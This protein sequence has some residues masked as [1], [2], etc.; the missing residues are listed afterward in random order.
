M[1]KLKYT[2]GSIL[3]IPAYLMYPFY[4]LGECI[5]YFLTGENN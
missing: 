1:R 4:W 3:C 5:E 2:I